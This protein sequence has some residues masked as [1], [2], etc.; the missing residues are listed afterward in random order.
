MKFF[1]LS[2]SDFST[3]SLFTVIGCLNFI[4]LVGKKETNISL[5]G[6]NKTVGHLISNVLMVV[7]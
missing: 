6:Q 7:L 3:T 4:F 1:K 5:I 2:W